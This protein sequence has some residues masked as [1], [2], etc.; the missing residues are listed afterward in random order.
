VVGLEDIKSLI[1]QTAVEDRVLVI[2]FWATWCVPCVRMFPQPHEGLVGLGDRL[3]AVSVTLDDPSR[4]AVAATFLSEQ[5]ALTDAYIFNDDPAARQIPAD[6]MEERWNNLA[7][8][9]ILVYDPQGVGSASSSMAGLRQRSSSW[10]TRCWH[11]TRKT[12]HENDRRGDQ[13]AI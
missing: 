13:L 8:P 3:R 6:G 10:W 1:A 2:D 5:H 4:G 9:A 7:V 11:Q 12:S